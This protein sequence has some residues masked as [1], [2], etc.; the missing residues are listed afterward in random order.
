MSEAPAPP[1]GG[2]I[3]DHVTAATAGQT[4]VPGEAIEED[5]VAAG[6]REYR[7]DLRG[8]RPK[9]DASAQVLNRLIDRG[10]KDQPN[11]VYDRDV[12]QA[13]LA[14]GRAGFNP[15]VVVVD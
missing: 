15:E 10:A 14:E 12:Y 2:A 5:P 8:G 7:N 9:Q 13:R 1:D 6:F 4:T 3:L 11:G